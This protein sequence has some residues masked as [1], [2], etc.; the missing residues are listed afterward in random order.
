MTPAD[1]AAAKFLG[2]L[3]VAGVASVGATLLWYLIWTT[4]C[5][6]AQV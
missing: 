1:I 6:P 5:D 4:F 2:V 3:V